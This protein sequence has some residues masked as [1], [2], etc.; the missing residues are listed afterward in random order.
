MTQIKSCRPVCVPRVS[1]VSLSDRAQPGP[2]GRQ[3]HL[4]PGRTGVL[5]RHL[6]FPRQCLVVLA[7]SNGS[8]PTTTTP[9]ILCLSRQAAGLYS[10]TFSAPL[11]VG[12]GRRTAP[13]PGTSPRPLDPSHGLDDALLRCPAPPPDTLRL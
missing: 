4:Y 11:F 9:I 13:H 7:V 2:S 6:G 8:T 3:G 12:R 1:V 10:P 5:P